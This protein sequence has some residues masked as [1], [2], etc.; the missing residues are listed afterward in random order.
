Q[1][2][3]QGK[4]PLQRETVL[5]GRSTRLLRWMLESLSKQARP[6]RWLPKSSVARSRPRLARCSPQLPHRASK[7]ECRLSDHWPPSARSATPA[8]P[9]WQLLHECFLSSHVPS[10]CF[11]QECFLPVQSA[12][13]HYHA[14]L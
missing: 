8:K 1:R 13:H 2:Q 6:P 5:P 11:L 10:L 3:E 9:C 14:G 4:L 12:A 7:P